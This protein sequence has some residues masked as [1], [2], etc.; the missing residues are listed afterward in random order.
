MNIFIISDELGRFPIDAE[1]FDYR[2][3]W[4][5]S[6]QPGYS[7]DAYWRELVGT[8]RCVAVDR[9]SEC[10][11]IELTGLAHPGTVAQ[12][13]KSPIFEGHLSLGG[14]ITIV[15]PVELLNT[16]EKLIEEQIKD[17]NIV[18]VNKEDLVD[19]GTLQQARDRIVSLAQDHCTILHS[20][21]AK[22][23]AY[24][25]FTNT[26]GELLLD[27][28]IPQRFMVNMTQGY[29][30][31]SFFSHDT[32]SC[33]RITILLD[34]HSQHILRAKGILRTDIG[35]KVIQCT[36][37]VFSMLNT[38]RNLT[39]S[40]LVII[41]KADHKDAIQKDFSSMFMI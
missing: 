18:I 19:K 22:V 17:A 9:N 8:L 13:V 41:T 15:N 32:L 31:M 4:I 1:L 27:D 3:E 21:H 35:N 6:L 24:A 12:I 29:A 11:L 40:K 26:S 20:I 10:I 5:S 25:L 16:R 14:I 34:W 28:S 36:Q 39:F 2:S 37:G 30:I 7:P 23:D 38:V 33:K